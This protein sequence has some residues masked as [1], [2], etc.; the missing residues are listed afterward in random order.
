MRDDFRLVAKIYDRIIKPKDVIPWKKYI[1]DLTA[2]STLLDVGGGTGRIAD[3]IENCFSSVIIYDI[4]LPMLKETKN[5]SGKI[6][7]V[8]GKVENL[9]LAKY[10]FDSVIMIDTLHHVEDHQKALSAILKVL[11]PGGI[12]VIEEP[13]IRKFPVK[14]IALMEKLLFMRSHF[15][16]PEEVNVWI[17]RD[18]F[19][20]ELMEEEN[21]YF[22]VIKR[23]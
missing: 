4:S 7:R 22:F 17:D 20:V 19:D 11:K 23:K 16:T 14:I 10:Y 12:F 8:C 2:D 13:D 15:L 21:N 5:K 3:A 6:A 9:A 18:E 1:C